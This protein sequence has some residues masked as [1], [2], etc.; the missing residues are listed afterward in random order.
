MEIYPTLELMDL[1]YGYAYGWLSPLLEITNTVV[2]RPEMKI[3]KAFRE[4]T[5]IKQNL[6]ERL[7]IPYEILD[8]LKIMFDHGIFLGDEDYV[9]FF[10]MQK[11]PENLVKIYSV[12]EPNYGIAY[13]VPS[14]LH[15]EIAVEITI[16][17]FLKM[18]PKERVM[19]AIYNPLRSYVTTLS[20]ALIPYIETKSKEG[21]SLKSVK[22]KLYK[23]ISEAF[24]TKTPIEIA[25][26][27]ELLSEKSVEETL[28]NLERQLSFKKREG[29]SI[30]L[31]VPV[32]Q[33]LFMEHSQKCLREILDLSLCY[34]E[35]LKD[36]S[37]K[38]LYIGIGTG[39]RVLSL[40]EMQII[41]SLMS[42]G[43]EL[44]KRKNVK[45]RFHVFGWT[46]PKTVKNINFSLIYSSDSIS[47]R[48]RAVDGKIYVKDANGLIRLV[49]VSQLNVN[50]WS[51]SCPACSNPSLRLMVLCPSGARKNDARIVHNLW[52][53][54][55]YI[56]SLAKDY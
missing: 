21:I 54:K 14:K 17:D 52:F 27:L 15:V 4:K 37:E 48:R 22:H 50:E 11:T 1:Y 53:L 24:Q 25:E 23:Y 5:S 9:K 13:D 41:N 47:V 56:N 38:C 49:N 30:F 43:L 33:G 12:L 29:L 39:G 31:L 35:F 45:L 26:P 44:A 36:N 32:V 46:S 3:G 20:N 2:L 42:Y 10:G 51:C 7:H 40:K 19:N 8:N 28:K 55:I 18:S 6:A 16:S 34:E